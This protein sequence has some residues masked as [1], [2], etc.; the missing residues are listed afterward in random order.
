VDGIISEI[1]KGIII[2]LGKL[3]DYSGS[4]CNFE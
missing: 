2:M 1:V 4:T 3:P